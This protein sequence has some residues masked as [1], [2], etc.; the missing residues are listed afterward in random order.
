[1]KSDRI[2]EDA[3]WRDGINA[4]RQRALQSIIELSKRVEKLEKELKCRNT[5]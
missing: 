2:T 3:D 1:M 5:K 4:F